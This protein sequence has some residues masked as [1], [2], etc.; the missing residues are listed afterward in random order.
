MERLKHFVSR[1]AFDIE[2]LGAKN[3]E[4]FYTEKLVTSPVD[5]FTLERRNADP[6]NLIPLK[7]K[8]GWGDT[9]AKNLFMAID[10]KR[11]V[12]LDRFLYALGIRQVGQATSR[13][14]GQAYGSLKGLRK[15]MAEAQDRRSPAYQD[16]LNI[17][18]IGGAVANDLLLFFAEPHNQAILDDLERELD[19]EN[20]EPPDESGSAIAGKTIVFTGTM[21]TMTRNEAKTGAQTLG[22]KVVGSV[23]ATTDLVVAGP[24]AG[25]KLKQAESHGIQVLDERAYLELIGLAR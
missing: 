25:S 10:E 9:S 2:G 6:N 24:G 4:N 14:L 18:S 7:N 16:L 8:E 15:A 21:E 5:I 3:I 17:E 11:R 12:N 22:A 23:S 13:L 1:N 19:I 20:Y